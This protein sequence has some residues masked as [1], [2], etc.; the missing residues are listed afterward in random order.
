MRPYRADQSPLRL[1]QLACLF[2]YTL[3]SIAALMFLRFTPAIQRAVLLVLLAALLVSAFVCLPLYFGSIAVY[4][5][6][7]GVVVRTGVLRVT[8]KIMRMNAIQYISVVITPFSRV[9]GLNFIVVHA[10]GGRMIIPFLSRNDTEELAIRLSAMIR[11][12]RQED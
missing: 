4:A 2:L 10:L 8:R 11:M 12:S 9:T 5:C 1:L 6:E 3:L 7:R